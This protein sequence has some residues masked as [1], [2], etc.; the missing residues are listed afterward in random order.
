MGFRRQAWESGVWG[1]D[2]RSGHRV[3]SLSRYQMNGNLKPEKPEKPRNKTEGPEQELPPQ[4]T[5]PP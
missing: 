3:S 4:A 2:Y 1:R 5:L